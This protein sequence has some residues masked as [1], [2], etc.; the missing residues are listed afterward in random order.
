MTGLELQP[1]ITEGCGQPARYRLQQRCNRCYQRL[2]KHGNTTTVAKPGGPRKPR[3]AWGDVITELRIAKG[4][5]YA[6]LSKATGIDHMTLSRMSRSGESVGLKYYI[7]LA[8]YFD[9]PLARLFTAPEP[10][11]DPCSTPNLPETSLTS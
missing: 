11:R 6:Q 5:T 4:L 2:R 3:T 1:C 7:W 9:V 10:E 8:D